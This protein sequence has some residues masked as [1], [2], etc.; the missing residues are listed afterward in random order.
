MADTGARPVAA[1][2]CGTNSTRLLVMERDGTVLER[3]MRI[4]RLGE[5]VDATHTLSRPAVE[6]TVSVLEDY[7][8]LM[9]RHGVG[10]A[11][12]VATSAA[13]DATNAEE[14]LAAAREATGIEPEILTGR[15]EG[16]LS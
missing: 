10:R 12:L 6:R 7:R 14:F 15:E 3:H 1:V 5:G 4:T 11:R 13:R 16:E 2:D 8:G 9:D